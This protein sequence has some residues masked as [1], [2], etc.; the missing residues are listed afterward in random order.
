M[1]D[2]CAQCVAH[3]RLH[4]GNWLG[5]GRDNDPCPPCEDHARSGC[6]GLDRKPGRYSIHTDRKV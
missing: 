1:A 3:A 4:S 5:I 6:P 2:D